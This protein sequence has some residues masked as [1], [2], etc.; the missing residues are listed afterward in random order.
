M[1]VTEEDGG[2]NGEPDSISNGG[3]E[4]DF[5]EESSNRERQMSQNDSFDSIF[6]DQTARLSP[7]A[8]RIVP[9]QSYNPDGTNNLF[10]IFLIVNAALGAGLLNFP[11]AF[12][13]AGG[14]GVAICVQ[15]VLIVFIVG[16]LNILAYSADKS[17]ASEASTVQDVVGQSLGTVA[18]FLTSL[19]IALYCFGTTVTFL[20]MIG[21]QY[22]RMFASLVDPEFCHRFYMNRDF[23]MSLTGVFVILPFCFSKRIDFLRLPSLLGVI[24]IIYLV[25]LIIYEYFY[26]GFAPGPIKYKPNTWTD[27]FLVVP[28]ICFGYQCHVSAVPIYSCMKHRNIKSFSIVSFI[29][30]AICAFAYSGAAS[31][32]YLTFGG[33]VNIDILL[34]YD[35]K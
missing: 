18:K 1:G 13:A 10:T 4:P 21:D 28:D 15:L 3:F 30:I 22:D 14:I 2:A 6:D 7:N 31:F 12:D 33:N 23:T 24:A 35:A 34:N 29:A 11:K 9:H 20:I 5:Y 26:G 16:A 8:N 32:G 25:G 19:A 17:S 27:V